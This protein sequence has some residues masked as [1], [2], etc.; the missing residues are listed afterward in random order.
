MRIGIGYDAHQLA[1]GRELILGGVAVPF[2]LG[3]CGHSDADVLTHAVIDAILGAAGLGD[4]GGMFPDSRRE[5]KDISSLLLLS[6]AYGEV[7]AKGFAVGNIDC[8]IVAQ[9]PRLSEYLPEMAEKICQVLGISRERVNIKAT[10]EECMGFTG[11]GR[12]MAAYAVA[13]LEE[14]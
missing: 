5:F 2:N 9:K 12:G 13:L 1:A 3:L 7:A 14:R 6:R 4:I 8:V 11:H 10:T